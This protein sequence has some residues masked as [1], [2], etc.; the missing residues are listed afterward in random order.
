M[1]RVGE[2]SGR[3]DW[4]AGML[5]DRLEAEEAKQNIELS[6]WCRILVGMFDAG[7]P[8]YDALCRAA[9]ACR[10]KPL[11][12]ATRELAAIFEHDPR[13]DDDY[14]DFDRSLPQPVFEAKAIRAVL[15]RHSDV[16]PPM[17][18]VAIAT[19]P[20][21][22]PVKLEWVGARIAADICR[23]I[24]GRSIDVPVPRSD[25]LKEQP[26]TWANPAIAMLDDDDAGIRAA[27]AEM[28]GTFKVS[29]AAGGLLGLLGDADPR[30]IKAAIQALLD[31]DAAPP[32]EALTARL[33]VGRP[34]GPPRRHPGAQGTRPSAR[35]RR[36]PGRA[37]VGP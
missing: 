9:E 1:V 4:S 36:T 16:F 15:D 31:L 11:S 7:V 6:F 27:A 8:P 32:T 29:S 30:V 28:L 26:D 25:L 21:F 37:A 14:N 3:L 20:G 33:S 12:Q 18:R 22:L 35:G 24:V 23:Q 19:G 5:A 34:V 13:R 17:L 2:W 10:S